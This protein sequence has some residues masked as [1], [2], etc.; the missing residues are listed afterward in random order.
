MFESG[1]CAS[2]IDKGERSPHVQTH[3]EA[4]LRLILKYKRERGHKNQAH[5][6]DGENFREAR[7]FRLRE[8]DV[9]PLD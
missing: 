3:L 8:S 5:N 6:D 2:E 1:A 4:E 9:G 7:R